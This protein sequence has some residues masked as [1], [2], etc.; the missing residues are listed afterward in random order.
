VHNGGTT[1]NLNG[2]FEPGETVLVEPA[3]RNVLMAPTD[4]TGAASGL[5]GPAGPSYSIE[6]GAASYGTVVPGA[7]GDCYSATQ[8]CY[9]LTISGQRPATHWDATF[10]ESRSDGLAK[11]WTLHVGASFGD[12][13]T[14]DPFYAF[15][16]TVLHNGVTAGCGAGVYCPPAPVTRAQ[17]AVFLL[18]AEHGASYAPPA[19][20]GVFAD[21]PCPGGFAADWIEQLATEGITGG[22]GSGNYC[23]N[24]PVTRAQMA[25]FLLKGKHGATYV[26]PACTGVFADVPCPAGFAVDSIEQLAAEGITGGCG[27]GNYCPDSSV[28]RGQMAVFLTKTFALALYG[29]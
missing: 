11:S 18:K 10:D 21:V 17:M 28:T 13:P 19:C 12:V 8:N 15:I 23:P 5:T 7:T 6:D 14:A 22:C 2:V 9:R 20:T 27:N 24:D 4:V 26:P 25:V 1:S 29:P 3:W 16:E